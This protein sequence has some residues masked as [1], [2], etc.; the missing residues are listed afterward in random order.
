[1]LP[2]LYQWSIEHIQK[3]FEA[4][5]ED[6]CRRAIDTTFS[7]HIEFM[8]NGKQLGRTDL[9]KFILSMVMASGF[10]LKVQWQNALEVPRDT[11]NRV[12]S[13]SLIPV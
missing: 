4:K 13:V 3:V 6:E 2:T 9:Q 7:H 1:M 5:D 8:S 12:R 11:S 10:R